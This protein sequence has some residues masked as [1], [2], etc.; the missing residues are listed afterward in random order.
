MV[1]GQANVAQLGMKRHNLRLALAESAQR[2]RSQA[3][4]T[5]MRM[6]LAP[7]SGNGVYAWALCAISSS[8]FRI[9]RPR[10]YRSYHPSS[11]RQSATKWLCR[12]GVPCD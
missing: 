12:S 2:L 5:S 6:R 7:G 11:Q 4:S 9:N 8:S 1:A 10:S 3:P